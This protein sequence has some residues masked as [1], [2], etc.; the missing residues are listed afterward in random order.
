LILVAG[1][2]AAIILRSFMGL[3]APSAAGLFCGALTNSGF[4]RSSRNIE[5]PFGEPSAETRALYAS[6]PLLPMAW[7]SVRVFGS[8]SGFLSEQGAENGSG[9]RDCEARKELGAEA[10]S[11]AHLK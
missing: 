10:F 5:K 6:S 8:Y 2:V 9:R 1:A 7:L 3:S 11:A 4:S